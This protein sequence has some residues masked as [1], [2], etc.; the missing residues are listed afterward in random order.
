MCPA[1]EAGWTP[2]GMGTHHPKSSGSKRSGEA[3]SRGCPGIPPSSPTRLL[4]R[5][6]QRSSRGVDFSK[7]S[8]CPLP[9]LQRIRAW[10]LGQRQRLRGAPRAL[11]NQNRGVLQPNSFHDLSQPL[12]LAAERQM[13]PREQAG[14]RK[15]FSNNPALSRRAAPFISCATRYFCSKAWGHQA[16]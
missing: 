14:G 7:E 10:G 9:T 2:R 11:S 15:V 1:G 12:W 8:G 5:R 13:L 6:L 3:G 4:T 16:Q